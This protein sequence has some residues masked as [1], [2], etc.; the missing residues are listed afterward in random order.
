MEAA[1]VKLIETERVDLVVLARYMQIFSNE[2]AARLAG[3]AINIH[4]SF[5]PAFV[6]AKP[7]HQAFAR[8]VKL[9]E[10]GK[11]SSTPQLQIASLT[12]DRV[13]KVHA[14]LFVDEMTKAWRGTLDW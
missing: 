11:T 8:G 13:Q 4:H 2:L 5:L 1:L 6:G 12:P 7:Y 14:H 9:I 10:I 3:R